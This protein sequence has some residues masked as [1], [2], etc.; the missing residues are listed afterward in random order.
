MDH[1]GWPWKKKSMEKTVV[2]SNGETEKVVDDKIELQNRLKSLNDKLTSVEAESNKHE[3]EAQEAIVG[4]EKTKAE[5]ASLKKKLD[6]ALNEKH[7]SEERSSHTDAGLKECVQQLRFVREE[8]ERRMHDALTKASQEYEQRLIV[9]KTE[10]AGT[11]KRLAEAEGENTQLS[12]ALLAKNKTVE[13]LNRER[14]RIEVDFNSLVSS[15]ESKEKENVSLRY[16]VRVLEKEL[17]LRNEEREFSRRTAEAS[18]KL[19]LENVKKV[20]KLESECQRLRVLVRKRLPGPAALSKMR[21][22]VEMLGRRR[23]NGSPN[24]LMIDSE[25]INNLTEQLCLMEEENKTLREA[26]NKK[27][28]ELQFS[29]NMYSRTEQTLKPSRSSNVSHEVSLASVSEFDND[30]KVSCADS[31]ACALLSELDNFKNKKQMGSSLVGTP[32][33]SEMKLMDDFAE[34]EKLAMVASTIDNRPG[35]SP[36]CPSDSISATGPVENESNENSSE[37]TKTPGTDYSLNPAAAPQ[38]IKSDSLPRSLHI[39]LKAVMEHKRIT[40]RNTDEV[41][42]DIRKA[43]SSVNHSSFSVKNHQEKKTI[44]VEDRLD[45]ECNISKSIHRIIEIIE[46]VSLKD[47]RHV[48]NGESERLS[49]YTA[50]VLQWKTTELSSVLQ[51]F[52]QTCYD[53]LDRKADM[54]KF[55][56]ELSSV[57]EWMVNHCFSLQ[58]VSTMRDEI[59]KQFEWDESRSGSE[60]DIGIFRQ[61]SEAEK[62][63]T[64]D[65]SF[66]ACK[67]QL[68]E[69]KPGNQKLLSNPVE[70]EANDKT[71]SASENELKLEEKQNMR[72]ELEIAAASEK[73]AE[74]QETILNLGKQLKALTNSKESTALLSEKLMSDLA[75]KSNNLAGAQPSQETTKPEKRLTSQRSSL[76][77]QMKAEDHNTG[78]SKD[79]KPQAADKNGKGGNSSVYNET[80]EALEQILLSDKSKGSDSNCFAIV[81]QKKSGGVKSLWRKLLGRN[82][83][84][85]GK[86]IHNPFAN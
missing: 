7:M 44:T 59:K 74:C 41:L 10:L 27:V 76:L 25:K 16:E 66:L 36:I 19:H 37:V 5:V 81:P 20:A 14:D 15:L 78:E 64:E 23:V 48:S 2:E 55:G 43:L 53:L 61:V 75:D 34:M 63:N 86:K 6:E 40:H 69:D 4:W 47:E 52:L 56:Q 57:L 60:V 38:D 85:K 83:K 13:D 51:R 21:N 9:I 22:E 26:L 65:V 33:A 50:R 24:S 79:Q 77:D 28:S 45:M 71:L 49:G 72:T 80:I 3:T 30:D 18:H 29:R 35:S 62:L 11:G 39:V 31:W 12:M 58:D 54:K 70:E 73:L 82:K 32:K 8:Q 84:S 68:I 1:K 42:E 17:E 67:D 46:G